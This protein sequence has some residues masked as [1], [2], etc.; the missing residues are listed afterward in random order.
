MAYHYF[1]NAKFTAGGFDG[2]AWGPDIPSGYKWAGY[3][4]TAPVAGFPNGAKVYCITTLVPIPA[5][6]F[7]PDMQEATR[8]QFQSWQVRTGETSV[9]QNDKW[10]GQ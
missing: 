3:W 6:Q 7:T 4:S 9:S 2:G 5:A 10:L 1:A 8:G